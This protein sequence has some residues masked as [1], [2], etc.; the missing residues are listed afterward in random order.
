MSSERP[1]A[2]LANWR[3]HPYSIWGFTHVDDLIPVA[4]IRG[5]H[6]AALP[7]GEALDLSRVSV[8]W[9]G[10][11]LAAEE[12]LRLTHT[13]GLLVLKDGNAVA[14]RYLNQ[15]PKDRHI[16]FSVSK[17]ITATL[18][19]VLVERGLLDP[20]APVV[21]YVPE[22]AG[23][24]Y[25]DCTLR[26]V[27][28][29]TVSIRFIEDYLDPEGDVARYRLAMGWNPPGARVGEEGLHRFITSLPRGDHPHGERFHYV[30]P[31]SDML[32]WII[33]RACGD[34]IAE[35]LT[36]HI[37]QPMAMAED[38][39]ITLD[40]KGAPRTAGG[41]CTSLGDLARFGEMVRNGGI[42][43]G[44]RIIPESWIEDILTNG[45]PAAWAKGDMAALFPRGRYR[46]KWYVPEPTSNLLC[47]IGIH[48]QWIYVDRAAGMVAVKQS[49]QPIPADDA[50]DRLSLALF[51]ALAQNLR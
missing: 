5:G 4:A 48:G 19:G 2:T 27:L 3:Q 38:A 17:S 14:E 37:W 36:R 33:E 21:G 41:I 7:K 8:D 35:L 10:S 20:E 34:S 47:A 45:D 39:F 6:G 28:D 40:A 12:A 1:T 51:A 46:S 42:Y 50:L 15:G 44:K 25:E 13:D 16:V 31:N 32:G 43:A 29:M 26:H 11:R 49:S 18:A 30:S 24:A 9:Q 23:S 22:A